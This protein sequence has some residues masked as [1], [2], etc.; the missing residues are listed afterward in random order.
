MLRTRHTERML[1]THRE[2]GLSLIELLV[3]MLI[4][5]A[6]LSFLAIR[7]SSVMEAEQS[8]QEARQ[9]PPAPATK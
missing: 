7:V 3:V 4:L 2:S 8:H 5:G 6:L 1:T 9:S